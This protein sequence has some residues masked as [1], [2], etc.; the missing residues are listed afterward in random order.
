M[1]RPRFPKEKPVLIINDVPVKMEIEYEEPFS[2]ASNLGLFT[3]LRTGR[4]NYY[5]SVPFPGFEGINLLDLAY[6][7]LDYTYFGQPSIEENTDFVLEIKKRKDLQVY[8][9]GEE[10]FFVERDIDFDNVEAARKNQ[11]YLLTTHKD[12]Y[13]SSRLYKNLQDLLME[14]KK[15]KPKI[16]IITGKWCLFFLSGLPG[17]G[18]TMGNLKD[19][20]PLGALTKYRASILSFH[21][22][23]IDEY[24]LED[25]ILYPIWPLMVA[26][27][28]PEKA[29]IMEFD[30]RRV[31]DIYKN[32]KQF[33]LDY[34]KKPPKQVHIPYTFN[35]GVKY[36]HELLAKLEEG[37]KI[38]SVDIETMFRSVIDCIGIAVSKDEGY[39]FP[40]AAVGTA[41]LWT[42]DEE[43]QLFQLIKQIL[44]HKNAFHLGQNYSYDCQYM[45]KLWGINLTPKHDTM[46]LH[47]ILY[48]FLPKDLAFLASVYCEFYTYWKDEVDASKE[49]P[50]TR[51]IYNVKDILYTLEV[52]ENLYQLL[53]NDPDERL[54]ELYSFQMD[55]LY[56]ELDKTMNR[57][58]AIDIGLKEKQYE[59]FSNLLTKIEEKV[60][61]ILGFKFNMNSTP[62]KKKL[63]K[64]FFNITLKTKKKKGAISVE[65][66]DASAMKMYIDEYPHL[67]ALLTLMLEYNSI[68]V[69]T[70]TFLGMKLDDDGRARTQYRIAGTKTGRLASTKNV[71]G[72]G[73]NLQNLPVSGKIPLRYSLEVLNGKAEIDEEW[74]NYVNSLIEMEE[75]EEEI[76]VYV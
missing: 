35:T 12:V 5:N 39:C 1:Y 63:F 24:N 75:Q 59:F 13:V 52:F 27:N 42:E 62:Q 34:Y 70:R 23:L 7:Y 14:I 57:G 73:A 44:E 48:N 60:N 28:A 9:N 16:I 55:K 41:S 66:N 49:S 8:E 74:E 71:W 18:E 40:F 72:K 10:S 25:H 47:H 22:S 38:M 65:T 76:E 20:K 31:G 50:E 43:F 37:P 46:V 15:I 61:D 56:P 26:Q 21:P 11:F 2:S 36:C 58:I 33:S 45:L 6:T 4:I 69:F 19:R 68:K 3:C 29:P 53:Q 67:Q 51:W 54:R 30:I 17:F 64:D 32:I